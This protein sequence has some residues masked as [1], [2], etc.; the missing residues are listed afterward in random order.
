M[1]LASLL[2]SPFPGRH[3]AMRMDATASCPSLRLLGNIVAAVSRKGLGQSFAYQDGAE[4]LPGDATDRDDGPARGGFQTGGS[5]E[6]RKMLEF[7]NLPDC[8]RRIAFGPF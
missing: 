1:V 4:I 5:R 8:C 2:R 3:T 6:R 7:G